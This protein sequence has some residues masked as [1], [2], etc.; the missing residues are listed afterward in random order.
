LTRDGGKKKGGEKKKGE[1]RFQPTLMKVGARK[2]NSAKG[3]RKRE[4]VPSPI[5]K[6]RVVFLNLAKKREFKNGRANRKRK[7]KEKKQNEHS[8]KR[9][10]QIFLRLEECD[11]KKKGRVGMFRREGREKT[12][13]NRT[14]LFQKVRKFGNGH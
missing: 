12:E 4:K 5:T 10:S 7:K 3:E 8:E 9:S 14:R 11:R 2:H 1:V 13:L 6:R